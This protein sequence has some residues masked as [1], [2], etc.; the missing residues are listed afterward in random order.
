MKRAWKWIWEHETVVWTA[1]IV[2]VILLQWPVLKGYYYRAASSAPPE[3]A[4][5][6]RTD[7]DAALVEARQTKKL[8]LVDFTADWCP[9]CIAMKHDVWPDDAV[10]RAVAESYVPVLIDTDRDTVVSARYRVRGI[11]TVLVVDHDGNVVRQGSFFTA[12]RM[13]DFLEETD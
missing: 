1:V 7:F 6:W 3:S 8:V 12:S 13:V 5:G 9:P 10:E 2:A 4:I 11:P